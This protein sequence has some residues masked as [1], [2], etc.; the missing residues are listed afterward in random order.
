MTTVNR[1][2][3]DL[4]ERERELDRATA[5]LDQALDGQGTAVAFLGP[6]GIGKT[7]LLG[8]LA[9][10]AGAAGTAVLAARGSEFERGFPF[11]VARQL[12][13]PAVASIASDGREDPAGGRRRAR[14][15]GDRSGGDGCADGGTRR[16]PLRGRSWAL[17]AGLEP[18]RA[19]AAVAGDRR[20]PVGRPRVAALDRHLCRRLEDLPILVALAARE[21]EPATD[22]SLLDALIRD[23]GVQAMRPA[24]LSEAAVATLLAE[25]LG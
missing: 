11:A 22:W 6:P 20:R 3:G 23:A 1:M 8:A 4:L 16:G 10:G 2:P 25:R 13:A 21:E 19:A 9:D 15:R 24:P 18:R 7:S 17:L 5:A 14:S 12:L